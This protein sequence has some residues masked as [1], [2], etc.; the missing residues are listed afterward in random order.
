MKVFLFI[1]FFLCSPG[2]T[3]CGH[4]PTSF[5]KKKKV[6]NQ[7]K[8]KNPLLK[9]NNIFPLSVGDFLWGQPGMWDFLFF[10]QY[11]DLFPVDRKC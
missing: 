10:P 6:N 7:K 5:K 11:C 4:S 1:E 3:Q 2:M 8:K 9:E